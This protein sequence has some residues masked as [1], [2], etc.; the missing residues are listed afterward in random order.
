MG[1][2]HACRAAQEASTI[3]KSKEYNWPGGVDPVIA[4]AVSSGKWDGAIQWKLSEALKVFR[5]H[6]PQLDYMRISQEG[7][8]FKGWLEKVCNIPWDETA[9]NETAISIS[10]YARYDQMLRYQAKCFDD[11]D[12]KN[13]IEILCFLRGAVTL[14]AIHMSR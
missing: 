1:S 8:S 13:I 11:G 2:N 10:V 5:A 9:S 12:R 6:T 7:M 4:N 3:K 14:M